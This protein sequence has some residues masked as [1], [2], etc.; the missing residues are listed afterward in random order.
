MRTLNQFSRSPR[1]PRPFG[2]VGT[3]AAIGALAL[4]FALPA[5]GGDDDTVETGGT[6]TTRARS[7]QAFGTSGCEVADLKASADVTTKPT[8]AVPNCAPPTELVSSDIVEGT[9][10]AAAPGDA[11]VVQY[12]GVAWSTGSTFDNSW[13]RGAPFTFDLGAGNV[14]QGWDKGVVGMKPGGRRLLILPPELAYGDAGAGTDIKPGETLVF[15]VDLISAT[16]PKLCNADGIDV[17]AD[18]ATKP[19]VTNPDCTTVDGLKVRDIVEGT[20][21]PAAAGNDIEVKYVGIAAATGEQ[22]DASWDRGDNFSFK[23]GSGNVIPGWDQGVAG[24]KEGG[25]RL[26]VIPADLAY[27][28][29]GSPPTIEPNAT[30]VF[31]V[32]LVKVKAGS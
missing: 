4:V 26:L 8:V 23:L 19:A 1:S 25:R 9:G 11:T 10:G 31:V 30:L 2:T 22:F 14:I 7:D 18:L 13:D 21:A 24:M 20:G 16:P 28:A 17:S 15:V 5:C 6:A 32:D 27:G 3:V 12:L 29:A